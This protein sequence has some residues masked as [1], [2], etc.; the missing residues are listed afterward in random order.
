MSALERKVI[1]G[2]VIVL[3]VLLAIA[4]VAAQSTVRL[5]QM[6]GGALHVR[7]EWA[8][9]STFTLILPAKDRP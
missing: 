3:A 2:F 9:G 4:G 7:S 5:A 1:L 6:L 8:K